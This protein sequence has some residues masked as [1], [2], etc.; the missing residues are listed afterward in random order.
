M[1]ERGGEAS[2]LRVILMPGANGGA[3]YMLALD[4]ATKEDD[5][6]VQTDGFKILLDADTAPFME[7]AEIDYLDG[8]LMSGFVVNNPNAVPG[9]ECACGGACGCGDEDL[10]AD[11]P[12]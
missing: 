12:Q 3:Q 6:V 2:A 10:E 11:P 5:T 7:G 8:L 1:A 4:K 9:D